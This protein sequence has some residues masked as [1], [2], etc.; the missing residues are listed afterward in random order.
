MIDSFTMNNCFTAL[1][2]E[3]MIDML[4]YRYNKL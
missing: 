1:L 2:R 4:Q 3:L